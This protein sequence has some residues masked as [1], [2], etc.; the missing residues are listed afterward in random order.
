MFSSE[1]NIEL[2]GRL[3]TETKEYV[4]LRLEYAKV[5]ATGKIAAALSAVILAMVLFVLAA[6]FIVLLSCT[7]GFLLQQF[8]THDYALSFGI[9]SCVYLVLAVVVYA[10]RKKWIVNPVSQL[11]GG[12][13]L[14]PKDAEAK[15]E[16]P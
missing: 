5:D 11:L 8:V 7:A 2:I 1:K 13:L 16:E 15:N 3:F 9:I 4:E 14:D 12:L 10:R 6:I